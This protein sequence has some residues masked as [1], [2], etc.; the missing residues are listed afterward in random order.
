MNIESRLQ[1]F[2]KLNT[3]RVVMHDRNSSKGQE[4]ACPAL[5][6]MDNSN[7][8]ESIGFNHRVKK[9]RSVDKLMTIETMHHKKRSSTNS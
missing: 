3:S 2:V 4:S 5:I 8:N 9:S 7:E 6:A 1:D